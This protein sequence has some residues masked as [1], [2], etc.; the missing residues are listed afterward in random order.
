MRFFDTSAAAKML[1]IARPNLQRLIR[2][3]RVPAPPIVM[4]GNGVRVRIWT[5]RD[6]HKVKRAMK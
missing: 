3:G 5:R 2:E 4:V 6:V 1:G